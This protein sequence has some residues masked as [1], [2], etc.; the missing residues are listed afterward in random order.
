MEL[1]WPAPS[2]VEAIIPRNPLKLSSISFVAMLE[3]LQINTYTT[4]YASIK[5]VHTT[6][7][8]LIFFKR[9]KIPLI[10]LVTPS[11]FAS[12]NGHC[13]TN[14][15]TSTKGKGEKEQK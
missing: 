2:P 5:K 14:P 13:K 3:N 9:K 8:F 12:Q 15:T 10:M 7:V 1:K 6:L 4:E 11:P